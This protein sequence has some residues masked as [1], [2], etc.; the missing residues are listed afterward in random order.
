MK[1]PHFPM[2]KQANG[3]NLSFMPRTKAQKQSGSTIC[4]PASSTGGFLPMKWVFL[5]GKLGFLTDFT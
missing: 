1:T 4:G 3:A 2:K 5:M